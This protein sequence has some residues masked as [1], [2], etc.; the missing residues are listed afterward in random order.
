MAAH[1]TALRSEGLAEEAVKQ[2]ATDWRQSGVAP[3][4]G[5]MLAFAEAVTRDATT[6]REEHTQT[7]REAGF[8]DADIL[9]IV[10]VTCLFNY[11]DR[12]ADALGVEV[13]AAFKGP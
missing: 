1:G 11:L 13:D 6:I 10:H 8:S 9:D 5:A 12:F 4:T 3:R 7:L 2:I